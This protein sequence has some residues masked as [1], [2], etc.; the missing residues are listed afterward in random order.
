M[1]TWLDFRSE[2]MTER[3]NIIIDFKY[4]TSSEPPKHVA[5]CPLS[6]CDWQEESQMFSDLEEQVYAH[7]QWHEDGM[8]Q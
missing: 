2:P 8:P 5:K 4:G 7:E 6:D 1:T 3:P